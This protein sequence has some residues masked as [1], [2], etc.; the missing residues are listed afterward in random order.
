MVRL[1]YVVLPQ[2]YATACALGFFRVLNRTYPRLMDLLDHIHK[3]YWP[4]FV[5]GFFVRN[6]GLDKYK[7]GTGNG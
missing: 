1:H 4:V 5:F 6:I 2:V 3:G 7:L